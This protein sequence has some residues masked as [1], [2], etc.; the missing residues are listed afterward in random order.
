MVPAVLQLCKDEQGDL[1]E[2]T[3]LLAFVCLALCRDVHQ[4]RGS[5]GG[6]WTQQQQTD[7][8]QRRGRQLEPGG[9]REPHLRSVAPSAERPVSACM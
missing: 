3:L 1:I 6:I 4:R 7:V 9:G 2:Y 8:R 5:V